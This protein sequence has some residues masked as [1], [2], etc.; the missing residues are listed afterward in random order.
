MLSRLLLLAGLLVAT[1]AAGSGIPD[2]ARSTIPQRLVMCPA[3]DLS[4]ELILRDFAN[5]PIDQAQVVM[6]F[7]GCS[8][9][10]HCAHPIPQ[11]VT[12]LTVDDV[13]KR[14]VGTTDANG[15]LVVQVAMTGSCL[16]QGNPINIQV[17]GN[18]VLLSGSSFLMSPDQNGDLIVDAADEA[19]MNDKIADPTPLNVLTADFNGDGILDGADL[20][21]L[22]AHATHVCTDNTP[23]RRRAWGR[24][25]LLYR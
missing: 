16:S 25:K 6:D 18:G 22:Q 17:Y 12:N 21:F 5:N 14:I 7:S 1:P 8:A 4:A 20:A 11:G 24:L 23:V 9:F 3:G 15:R 19:I 13:N 2:P 10:V